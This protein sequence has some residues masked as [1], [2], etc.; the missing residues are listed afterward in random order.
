M[1]TKSLN[2]GLAEIVHTARP[3][4]STSFSVRA[5]LVITDV[6]GNLSAAPVEARMNALQMDVFGEIVACPG[7]GQPHM[8]NMHQSSTLSIII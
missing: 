8:L 2:R 4:Y 1:G 5:Q 6:S 7:V 3:R